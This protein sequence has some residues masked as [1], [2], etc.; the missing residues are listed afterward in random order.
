MIYIKLKSNSMI[1]CLAPGRNAPFNKIWN[2]CVNV[3]F[4]PAKHGLELAT[5]ERGAAI[6]LFLV[7]P[8]PFNRDF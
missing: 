5:D 7:S 3:K 8:W 4:R 2:I 1:P 6:E